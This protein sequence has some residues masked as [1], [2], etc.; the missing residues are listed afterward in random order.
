MKTYAKTN[1][2]SFTKEEIIENYL[3]E[4]GRVPT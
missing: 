2:R 4:K 1:R 3:L